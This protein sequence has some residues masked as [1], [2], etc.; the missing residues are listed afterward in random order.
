MIVK[1]VG[2]KLAFQDLERWLQDLNQKLKGSVVNF[3]MNVGKGFF[4]LKGQ[5]LDA[6]NNALMLSPYK[7]KWGTCMIQSWVSGFN[8]DNPNNLAFPTWVALRRLPFEHHDQALTIAGTL[9]EVIGIDTM[10]E[11]AKDPR[12][13]VNLMVTKGWVTSI[14]LAS[15]DGALPTHKALVDYVKLPM[16]CKACQSWKHRV[17]EC[18]EIQKRH[19]RG[20]RRPM[21]DPYTF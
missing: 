17:R 1:F 9:G 10:N 6:I 5:D 8:P 15:E 4:F 19:V 20:G 11:T 12:F 13:C 3:F 2:P 18:I 7:S 21:R 14:D 16:R